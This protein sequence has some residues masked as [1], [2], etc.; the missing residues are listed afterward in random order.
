MKENNIANVIPNL[1]KIRSSV[2]EDGHEID[3]DEWCFGIRTISADAKNGLLLNGRV[4]RGLAGIFSGASANE[5][6]YGSCKPYS[7][8]QLLKF[9]RISYLPTGKGRRIV[10][11]PRPFF[12]AS[13]AVACILFYHT[14]YFRN[15]LANKK[16]AALVSRRAA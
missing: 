7:K 3:T 8:G 5:D 15:G 9:S 12:F 14:V 2:I 13:T 16:V 4:E 1:Y 10:R 11:I 6:E